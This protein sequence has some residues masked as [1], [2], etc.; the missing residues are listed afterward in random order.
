[1]K[2]NKIMIKFEGVTK[3]YKSGNKPIYALSDISFE[4]ERG[5]FTSIV[6]K[7][8]AGKTTLVKLLIGE[9]PPTKGDILFDGID[10]SRIRVSGLQKI[11]KRI[12]VVY[13]DY[14]L[15]Q[16]KTVKENLSYI[17]QVIGVSDKS[18]ARDI[19]QVL[20]LVDLRARVNDFPQELSGGEQQRLVIG[21][22]LIHRPEVLVADEP[23]GN[24]DPY[25]T[26]EII[27]LL[28]KVHDMGTTILLLTH[29]K[30][31][32]DTLQKRVIT[33]EEGKIIDD[34]PEGKFIL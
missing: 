5:E 15:L 4:I 27:N 19:P 33:L 14:K 21:R 3:I 11:R 31:I 20:E 30:G 9:E 8:G 24:L 7:S 17:M 2:E 26:Y 16:E 13:Q 23:T 34:D 25:N 29:D 1:M 6:G 22:A 18:I 28:K 10:T 32:I 12:G